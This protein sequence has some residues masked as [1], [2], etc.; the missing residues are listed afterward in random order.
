MFDFSVFI[1]LIVPI[2]S[3]YLPL[4]ISLNKEIKDLLIQPQITE[5]IRLKICT[6][7]K[8][9]IKLNIITILISL[10][11]VVLFILPNITTVFE[12]FTPL[13]LSDIGNFLLKLVPFKEGFLSDANYR[14]SYITGTILAIIFM[15]FCFCTL[16]DIID[17]KCFRDYI[18]FLIILI[19]IVYVLLWI[20]YG[21][22][23]LLAYCI[24][25]CFEF[26][27]IVINLACYFVLGF[28]LET[29]E[30]ELF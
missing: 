12:N 13:S 30:D 2:I 4:N 1:S 28:I 18:R 7:K 21:L 9:K 8:I 3:I 15:Y 29:I 11:I 19:I 17:L 16:N 6:R 25:H 20:N 23:K 26:L 24:I 22:S 5:E 27:S 14:F 10:L